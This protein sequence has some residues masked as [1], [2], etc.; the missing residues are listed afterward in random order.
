MSSQPQKSSG[1]I[2]SNFSHLGPLDA[3]LVRLGALAEKYF[4]DDANT[5]MVKIRQF[6]EC[7]A[8]ILASRMGIFASVS[9]GQ[10]E[11]L[12]RLRDQGI[13]TREIFQLFDEIRRTGNDANHAGRDDHGAALN[14]LKYAA[15]LG[16][17]F[18]RTVGK[19]DFKP[20]PFVPPSA[21]K[22]ES[23]SLRVELERLT[24]VM[25]A[26]RS[27]RDEAVQRLESVAK[28]KSWSLIALVVPVTAVVGAM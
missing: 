21:P 11:L 26:E 6:G 8:Q 27:A 20:G 2:R 7:L 4:A 28:R 25:E 14:L 22:D 5:S 9:E 19:A 23:E 16:V 12:R 15:Q 18:Q 1:E 13:L 3:Q 17:W 24:A 10:Y